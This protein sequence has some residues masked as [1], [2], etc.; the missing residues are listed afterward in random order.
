MKSCVDSCNSSV[1]SVAE[2]F[3]S[4]ISHKSLI[5]NTHALSYSVSRSESSLSKSIVARNTQFP[6]LDYLVLQKVKPGS[7]RSTRF[8]NNLSTG[9]PMILYEIVGYSFCPFIERS[10]RKNNVYF[11]GDVSRGCIYAK[12]HDC[13]GARGKEIFISDV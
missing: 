2:F 6:H 12:C 5:V 7:I 11:I 1:V 9:K 8:Y 3:D 13:K 10:H 4:L